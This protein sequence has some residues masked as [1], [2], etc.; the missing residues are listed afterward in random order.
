MLTRVGGESVAGDVDVGEPCL[1]LRSD[2]LRGGGG[3]PL[4]AGEKSPPAEPVSLVSDAASTR[5]GVISNSP[6]DGKLLASTSC[7]IAFLAER[8][9][10]GVTICLIRPFGRMRT[11]AGS[12][13]IFLGDGWR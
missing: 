10:S 12:S 7:D 3:S 5:L 9:S 13:P 4:D 1:R 6:S 11:D 2:L 8:I